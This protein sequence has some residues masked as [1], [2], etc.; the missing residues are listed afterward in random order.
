MFG[1]PS[2]LSLPRRGTDDPVSGSPCSRTRVPVPFALVCRWPARSLPTLFSLPRRVPY[3]RSR[4]R[5]ALIAL[6]RSPHRRSRATLDIFSLRHRRSASLD[7]AHNRGRACRPS[8]LVCRWSARSLPT[9]SSLSRAGPSTCEVAVDAHSSP[10]SRSPHR[11]SSATLDFFFAG[12]DR[13][14]WTWNTLVAE[15]VA[16][17]PRLS[18]VEA[19]LT[20]P[21]SAGVVYG[22]PFA[23]RA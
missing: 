23:V 17:H 5:R 4:A 9:L 20:D 13:R 7:S 22:V 21:F 14:A 15:C 11:R 16:L 18:S 19:N 8:P 2:C 10:C 1:G 6:S 3:V 12:V